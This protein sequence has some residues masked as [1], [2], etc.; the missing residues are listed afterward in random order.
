MLE[1]IPSVNI[2]GANFYVFSRKDIVSPFCHDI[3]LEFLY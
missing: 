1:E 3:V 2:Y